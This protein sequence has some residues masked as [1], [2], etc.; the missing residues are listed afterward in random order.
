MQRKEQNIP[1]IT[2]AVHTLSKFNNNPEKR[3]GIL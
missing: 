1:D 3:I 2:Y